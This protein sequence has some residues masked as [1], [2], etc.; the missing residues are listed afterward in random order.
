MSLFSFI[1]RHGLWISIPLF[2]IAAASLVYLI[3]DVIK[4][5]K[6]AHLISVPL[7][8]TQAVDFTEAGRV[9]L[10]MEGPR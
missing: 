3:R 4:V 10:C 6:Q 5:M 2:I 7:V 8:E 9:V 1:Y